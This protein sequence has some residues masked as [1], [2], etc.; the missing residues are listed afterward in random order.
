VIKAAGVTK[1]FGGKVAPAA[2]RVSIAR[3]IVEQCPSSNNVRRGGTDC[4]L[5]H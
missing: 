2:S 3:D 4:H 1:R 5:R